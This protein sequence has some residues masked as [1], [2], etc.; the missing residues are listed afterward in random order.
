LRRTCCFIDCGVR[1][2][3]IPPSGAISGFRRRSAIRYVNLEPGDPAPYFAGA[4]TSNPR[5]VFDTAAGRYLVLCMLGSAGDPAVRAAITAAAARRDV[6]DDN[7]ASLFGVSL[8][9][10][11]LH[12]R[13]LEQSLP[14]VRHFWDFD[15]AIGRLYG[16]LPLD[17][18]SP[19]TVSGRRE[20]LEPLLFRRMWLVLDPTLRV[21]KVWPFD[22]RPEEVGKV[23]EYVASLPPPGHFSGI[24]LQAP[25]LY[26]PNVFEAAL[27]ERLIGLYLASGGQ[28]SGFMRERDGKTVAVQD[29]GFKRRQDYVLSD[30]EVIQEIQARVRRRIR[31]EIRKAFQFDA[32]RMERYI[33]ACYSGEDRGFLRPH[34]DNTTKGTAHRRFAVSINLNADFEGGELGFPEYGAQ[35]FKPPPGGAVVFSC[36]LLHTVH[37]VRKG[38]RYA[39]LPFLYDDAAAAIRESNNPYLGAGLQ[40]YKREAL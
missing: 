6:F 35:T 34:R 29:P 17:L 26:L 2:E 5:F 13:R 40:P 9:P 23:I 31:P 3:A 7:H 15:G 12:E 8:D 16:A 28:P 21:L 1:T 25:V 37:E 10:D 32:S 24:A 38:R 19:E 33:V 39:F 27:C 20:I 22:P 4:S 11:D 18:A 30:S 14:G 36:S